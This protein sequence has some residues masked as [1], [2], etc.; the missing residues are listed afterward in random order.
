MSLWQKLFGGRESEPADHGVADSHPGGEVAE[1]EPPYGIGRRPMPG[2]EDPDDLLPPRVGPYTRAPIESPAGTD[3]PTY[4]AYR[5]GEATVFVEMGVCDSPADAREA[6]ATAKAETGAE[7]PGVPQLFLEW[8][9]VGC[10]RTVNRL[11]AFVA[12][13]RGRYYFSAH[14]KGGEGDLDEF[15]EAFPY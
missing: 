1:P 9:G 15:M 3:A 7:F 2:G 6:L 8:G 13:T 10:L 14:A 11:G 4:A 5:R 12:W